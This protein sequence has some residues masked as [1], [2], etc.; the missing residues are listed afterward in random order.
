MGVGMIIKKQISLGIVG[1]LL[2]LS[3]GCGGKAENTLFNQPSLPK[4]LCNPG[5]TVCLQSYTDSNMASIRIKGKD[6]LLYEVS[7][8][9]ERIATDPPNDYKFC[10]KGREEFLLITGDCSLAGYK[11]NEIKYYFKEGN[12]VIRSN[13]SATGAAYDG[14]LRLACVDGRF[15]FVLPLVGKLPPTTFSTFSVSDFNNYT[16][17][18]Y[19]IEVK[20]NISDFENKP[21]PANIN[22]SHRMRIVGNLI[23]PGA[24]SGTCFQPD[25]VAG[26]CQRFCP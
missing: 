19:A 3:T 12:S 26:S 16:N 20:L 25:F 8:Y 15:N 5:D 9:K 22:M 18:D 2:L 11:T 24:P 23:V 21:V 17:V 1:L 4:T 13:D 6:P 14:G 7:V 10:V